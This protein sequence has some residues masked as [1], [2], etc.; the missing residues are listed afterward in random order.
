MATIIYLLQ[1]YKE[2]DRRRGKETYEIGSVISFGINLN[3]PFFVET[4]KH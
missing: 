1:N 3:K 4:K 2:K